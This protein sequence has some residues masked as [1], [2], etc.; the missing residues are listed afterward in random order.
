MKRRSEPVQAKGCVCGGPVELQ[1]IMGVTPGG[2]AFTLYWVE[3]L[4]CQTSGE[5]AFY[6]RKAV[7][8]W[9]KDR[10]NETEEIRVQAG[11]NDRHQ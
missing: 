11:R 2:E 10:A 8:N 7:M 5:P 6:K 3:C 9:N 1:T 4:E